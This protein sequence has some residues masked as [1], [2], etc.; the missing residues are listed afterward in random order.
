MTSLAVETRPLPL[1]EWPAKE[2]DKGG[3]D[4][5][6]VNGAVATSNWSTDASRKASMRPDPVDLAAFESFPASDPPAWLGITAGTPI[7][8]AENVPTERRGQ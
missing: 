3:G 8:H 7:R 5:A 1:R 2:T 6:T 4:P